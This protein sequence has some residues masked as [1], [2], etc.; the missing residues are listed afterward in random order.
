MTDK[1]E[2]VFKDERSARRF[3]IPV[4]VVPGTDRIVKTKARVG[5]YG[6]FKIRNGPLEYSVSPGFL[7]SLIEM[8]FKGESLLRSPFPRKGILGFESPWFGGVNTAPGTRAFQTGEKV[9]RNGRWIRRT[10]SS[11]KEWEGISVKWSL[12]QSREMP[13]IRYSTEY[14]TA[15]DRPFLSVLSRFENQSGIERRLISSTMVFPRMDEKSWHQRAVIRDPFTGKITEI[16]WNENRNIIAGRSETVWQSPECTAS[17][18]VVAAKQSRSDRYGIVNAGREGLYL[19]IVKWIN[20]APGEKTS[21]AVHFVG[22]HGES[23]A[24]PE[25]G[26]LTDCSWRQ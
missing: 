25:F 19:F 14:L 13:G 12:S 5:R 9:R 20:L 17:L 8:K 23:H 16:Y 7:G 3:Y 15:P 26:V 24:G 1:L 11:G 6:I 10:D 4:I 2:A 22:Y 18:A 21:F